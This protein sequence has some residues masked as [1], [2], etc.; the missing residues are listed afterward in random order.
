MMAKRFDGSSLQAAAQRLPQGG[1]RMA[2]LL[3]AI[4]QADEAGDHYWRMLLRY[5]YACQAI[6]H[7][8]P[9]KA[10]PAAAEFNSIFQLHGEVLYAAS[11]DGAPE[12]HLMI[13]QMG[14][15]PIVN[16]PQIPMEQWE[17]QMQ[18][19]RALVQKYHEGLRTYWSQMCQFWQYVDKEQAYAYFQKFWKTGRDGLS[20]CRA[21]ER[22]LAV[23]MCL[24]NG[25]RAAA[26]EYAKPME[27]GRVWF[28]NDTPQRYWLAYLEDALDRGETDRARIYA[29]KLFRKADRDRN[30]LSFLGAVIRA[31]SKTEDD[32][33]RALHLA[34]KRLEWTCG[35][36]DQKKLYDYYKGCC[37]CFQALSK[38]EPVLELEPDTGESIP[39]SFPFYNEE[40]VYNA[41][42]LAEWFYTQARD[43]AAAFDRRNGSDYFAR[44]LSLA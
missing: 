32:L 11:R 23:R 43:T 12:M 26:D 15:D 42:E 30:D 41:G 44:D 40:G 36:W 17:E 33:G 24:L 27:Q 10:M 28:C 29:N 6:F 18:A 19:F 5:D 21:C 13:T 31:W 37:V 20:D 16:L 38:R 8:D 35:M 9:P 39:E 3:D 7:D 2:A 25:D 14:I 4:R 22:S 34:L 1:P